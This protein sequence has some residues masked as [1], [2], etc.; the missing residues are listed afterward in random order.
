MKCPVCNR[1]WATA[2]SV[3]PSCGSDIY[4]DESQA[5]LI[6]VTPRLEARPSPK[7]SAPPLPATPVPQLIAEGTPVDPKPGQKPQPIA[8]SMGPTVGVSPAQKKVE[9]GNLSAA[10]TSPTLIGFQSKNQAIPDWRI[11]L[12][13]A[14]KLR[15]GEQRSPQET[16]DERVQYPTRGA[17]ALKPA[18]VKQASQ[19]SAPEVSDPI[20]AKAMRR[21]EESR[22][23]FAS[24]DVARSSPASSRPFGVVPPTSPRAAGAVAPARV[25]PPKP[26]LVSPAPVVAVAVMDKR[27]TNKLPPLDTITRTPLASPEAAVTTED[28]RKPEFAEIK[29]I[30]IPAEHVE[31]E[32][33]EVSAAS[34]EIEDLAPI[35]MRFGAGLFDLIIG[36]F[37]GMLLLSPVAFTG[38]DWVSLAGLAAFAGATSI[39]LFFYMT[40]CLGFF[41][42]TMGMRLFSLELVDAVEN[43]Y[44]TLRQAAANSAVFLLTLPFAG[45]G[46]LTLFYNEEK[47]AVH[48]L[49]SGTI[50]VREF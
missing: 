44:P 36:A 19:P 14:V 43:E 1:S 33:S 18:I 11:E 37:A 27:D 39:F 23:T 28:R 31:L 15:K 47:R 45:A 17:T 24:T 46:F 21:I 35:S 3:C 42:K 25:I 9:T 26:R 20:V 49:L 41:G 6:G 48:D 29:R 34:D 30:H 32:S 8:P 50:L 4:S 40:I 22:K 5:Q 38:S 2:L 13:N 16:V 10:K 12:Q 7:L